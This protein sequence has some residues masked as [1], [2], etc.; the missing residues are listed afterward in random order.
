MRIAVVGNPENRRVGLFVD[1]VRTAGLPEPT[2]LPWYEI[3]RGAPARIAAGS[4]V[5]LDSPGENGE[6]DRLLRRAAEPAR[7]GE[8]VGLAAWYDGFRGALARVAG[9]A[10]TAGAILVQDP[11]EVLTMFD[12][13][14]CHALLR[15]AG[16]P[17]PPALPAP[18]SYAE[19]RAAMAEVGWR[20]VFVK[21]VHGSSAAGVIALQVHKGRIRATTPIEESGGRLFNSLRVREYRDEATVARLVDRLA[22]DG[23][24]VE[25]WFP[26][27][28]LDGRVLD[29]RVVVIAQRP[30]HVVVRTSRT[31]MTNLH[32]GGQRGDLAALRAAA[33]SDAY[34]GALQTCV[35]VAQC[36][37]RTLH[38]GVDLMFS[39]DWRRHVVAEVNAFGDLLPGLVVDGRD[40]YGEQIAALRSRYPAAVG[41][42]V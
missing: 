24:H 19:L 31:A 40:T 22:P 17:V 36:F 1:A 21:P 11:A 5:R 14:A 28:A 9:L 2:V 13:H 20:R 16:L 4:L 33:G 29:L 41:A 12:K 38:V 32:L 34:D 35:R 6:V 37:P 30:T 3:A 15:D 27:A 42:A 18:S 7:H 8:L 10:R 23:L 25:R 39:P 26:K